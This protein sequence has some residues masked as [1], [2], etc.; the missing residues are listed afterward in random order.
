MCVHE[1]FHHFHDFMSVAILFSLFVWTVT[2]VFKLLSS[3]ALGVHIEKIF[4]WLLRSLIIIEILNDNGET[5]QSITHMSFTLQ[6]HVM[7]SAVS[8][9]WE[10]TSPR[11][12]MSPSISL[13][14]VIIFL[15]AFTWMPQH[16]SYSLQILQ[17]ILLCLCICGL[18]NQLMIWLKWN[19]KQ[20][21]YGDIAGARTWRFMKLARPYFEESSFDL[22]KRWMIV[23]VQC[24]VMSFICMFVHSICL[25]MQVPLFLNIKIAKTLQLLVMKWGHF[26]HTQVSRMKIYM[27]VEVVHRA[28][29]KWF[30]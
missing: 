16:F 17:H 14:C 4:S 23:G 25:L 13:G 11:T 2:R 1:F 5:V 3:L 30:Q 7:L 12:L 28:F 21:S 15:P 19:E 22:K 9:I 6:T 27:H 24:K 18:M 20:T 10:A 26:I 8:A 29:L